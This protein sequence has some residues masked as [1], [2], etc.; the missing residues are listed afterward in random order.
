VQ[1]NSTSTRNWTFTESLLKGLRGDPTVDLNGDGQVRLEELAR[2]T[3][4]EMAFAEGQ[5][6]WFSTANGFAPTMNLAHAKHTVNREAGR[7][8]EAQWQGKWW[9]AYVLQVSSGKTQVHY[10]GFGAEWD[11]WLGPDRVRAYKPRQLAAGTPIEVDWQDKWW[12]AKVVDSGLGLHLIN[13]DGFGKEW[14]EWV[15]PRRI[16]SRN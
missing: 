16:R 15:G 4:Q 6:S 10:A 7:R 5:K 12:P 2:Y 3:E 1:P 9:P 13:Y 11:E 14:D 8:V